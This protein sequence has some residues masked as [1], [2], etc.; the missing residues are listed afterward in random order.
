MLEE[1]RLIISLT[2]RLPISNAIHGC[3]NPRMGLVSLISMRHLPEVSISGGRNDTR[4]ALVYIMSQLSRFLRKEP[5]ASMM[6]A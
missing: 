4:N 6:V 1:K 2:A 3:R 5:V